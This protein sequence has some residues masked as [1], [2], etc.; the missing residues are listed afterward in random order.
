FTMLSTDCFRACPLGNNT[1]LNRGSGQESMFSS[2]SSYS[3]NSSS[4]FGQ[5]V[6]VDRQLF[7]NTQMTAQQCVDLYQRAG[8]SSYSGGEPVLQLRL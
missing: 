3:N 6:P 5:T 8:G 4:L 2:A 1:S 7:V